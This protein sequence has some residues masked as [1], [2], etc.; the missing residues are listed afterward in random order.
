MSGPEVQTVQTVQTLLV[1]S[2]QSLGGK[3][4]PAR[5]PYWRLAL[6]KQC[7]MG[8]RLQ[9]GASRNTQLD[10]GR[11]DRAGT[12]YLSVRVSQ[13]R[14]LLLYRGFPCWISHPPL[15][16]PFEGWSCHGFLEAASC[17]LPPASCLLPPASCLLPPAS[18]LLPPARLVCPSVPPHQ[19][20]S[21][22]QPFLP[23]YPQLPTVLPSQQSLTLVHVHPSFIISLRLTS[24][25]IPLC[26]PCSVTS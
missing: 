14:L 13:S 22:A 11:L 19:G 17:L 21:S 8:D 7:S 25:P 15:F 4:G 5:L 3:R 6:L 23:C 16:L 10:M 1:P 24:T 12:I 2:W 9:A 18:C 26:P 20:W